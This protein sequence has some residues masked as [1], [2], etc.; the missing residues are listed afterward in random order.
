MLIIIVGMSSTILM[1]NNFLPIININSQ[2]ATYAYFP[3]KYSRYVNNL[4]SYISKDVYSKI[5]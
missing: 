4:L 1:H 5:P 2:I 3:C